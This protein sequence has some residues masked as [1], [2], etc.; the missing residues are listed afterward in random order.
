MST[1][2]NGSATITPTLILGYESDAESNNVVHKIIGRADPDV[3]LAPDSPR[4]GTLELFFE[5]YADAWEARGL[6]AAPAVWTL[7]DPDVPAVNMSYV[8][9]GSMTIS[10]DP[11]SRELWTLSVGYQEVSS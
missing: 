11:D 10:L 6:H 7:T 9:D 1:I 3:S 8:R 5:S 4:S 2:S